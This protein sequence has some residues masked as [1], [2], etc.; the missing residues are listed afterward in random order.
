MDELAEQF[1]VVTGAPKEVGLKLLEVTNGNL[2]MAITMQIDGIGPV[3]PDGDNQDGGPGG[4]PKGPGDPGVVDL[5]GD[6][7]EEVRPPIPRRWDILNPQP[8]MAVPPRRRPRGGKS[9]VFDPFRDFAAETRQQEEMLRTGLVASS[10]KTK[11]KTLEDLFR[12][13]IDLMFSGSFHSV[14]EAGQNAGKWLMVNI[15]NTQEFSCQKLNRDVWS[16]VTVKSIIRESFVFWQVFHDSEDGMKYS[17][18]YN[19]TEYP[20]VAILDPRTGELLATWHHLDTVAFCDLVMD[21]LTNHPC[22]DPAN[23]QSPPSKKV[24]RE[25]IIDADEEKQLK[26]AIDASLAESSQTLPKTS[27]SSQ[28]NSA[29]DEKPR[30]ELESKDI[31]LSQSS[32]SNKTIDLTKDKDQASKVTEV[33][34]GSEISV[35]DD[36]FS[37][38]ESDNE[39]PNGVGKNTAKST[40]ANG[41]VVSVTTDTSDSTIILDSETEVPAPK[42]TQISDTETVSSTPNDISVI[43]VRDSDALEGSTSG[44]TSSDNEDEVK[45]MLRFPDGRRREVKFKPMDT[46]RDL[47]A[48]VVKEGYSNER[49][50][51][52]TNFPLRR[53]SV[54]DIDTTLV[55]AKLYPRETVFIQE[56]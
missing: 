32:D 54:W 15:Q 28:S 2:E 50:E 41:S 29:N 18:F 49:Y 24:R 17:Q 38:S 27:Q 51:L 6:Q 40:N 30:T 46:L 22:F 3:V 26:A 25:S 19:V 45:I 44:L 20:Y 47:R 11:R 42:T 52:V 21:F 48:Y 16:D 9:S 39:K 35:S 7:E 53:L 13:P 1:S 37:F 8:Y 55:T 31:K 56:R 23:G 14:R 10:S 5:S 43:T 34:S 12:P 36:E 33:D 4:R